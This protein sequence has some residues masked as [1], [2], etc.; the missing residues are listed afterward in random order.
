MDWRLLVEERIAYIGMPLHGEGLWLWLLA[1]LTGDRWH[2][3]HDAHVEIFSISCVRDFHWVG[4]LGICLVS[5]L[6]SAHAKRCNVSHMRDFLF[7]LWC[8]GWEIWM[9]N[10]GWVW[11]PTVQTEDKSGRK[12]KDPNAPKR[13][14]G[15]YFFFMHDK[16]WVMLV[17]KEKTNTILSKIFSL[18]FVFNSF[19]LKWQWKCP[20]QGRTEI[21]AAWTTCGRD[22][23]DTWQV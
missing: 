9:K 3:T 19:I 20:F 2:V 5:M 23:Q 12:K 10:R 21:R 8:K 18:F 17:R 11:I 13:P 14:M 4:Q 22:V 7:C 1:L 15:A 6:L 16:R